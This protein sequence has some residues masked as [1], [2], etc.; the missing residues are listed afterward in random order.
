MPCSQPPISQVPIDPSKGFTNLVL[1]SP[2]S[3]KCSWPF[4]TTPTDLVKTKPVKRVLKGSP[5]SAKSSDFLS[6]AASFCANRSRNSQR[7]QPFLLPVGGTWQPP[8]Q[9]GRE[10]VPWCSAVLEPP[11]IS[12]LQGLTKDPQ[13]RDLPHRLRLATFALSI[14]SNPALRHDFSCKS[15][16]LLFPQPIYIQHVE[17]M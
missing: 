16:K 17:N 3:P 4:Q 6:L 11:H 13:A 1:I 15:K 10:R 8:P 14:V 2:K 9:S 5:G 7:P 12:C